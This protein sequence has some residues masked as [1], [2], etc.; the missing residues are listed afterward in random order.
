MSI[1]FLS[2]L[3][4]V[5][6]MSL[7]AQAETLPYPDSDSSDGYDSAYYAEAYSGSY[8]STPALESESSSKSIFPTQSYFE[9]L[10]P[11]D[12]R[13]GHGHVNIQNW[14]TDVNLCRMSSGSWNFSAI[15]GLRMTWFNGQGADEM[16]VDRLYTIWL[17][18]NASCVIS[19]KTRL[20]FGFTPEISTDFDTWTHNNIFFGGHAMITGPLNDRFSYG[21]GIGYYPQLGEAPMLPVLQFK[22]K[23]GNKWSLQ[24]EGARLS[25]TKMVGE[26]LTWGPFVSIVSGTWTIHHDRRVRQ[27]EWIS[28]VA[29]VG[30]N[31]GLGRWGSVRPRLMTDVG[32]SFGNSGTLKTSNGNHE[33]EKRHY[34][35]VFYL[36]ACIQFVF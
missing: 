21:I 11:M 14:V 31:I 2:S 7:A 10:G 29:G 3:S 22:W 13:N 12:S 4:L 25:Y 8:H 1:R 9:L 23:T 17:N 6:G 27:F 32:F 16:D 35:P 36:R 5:A 28:G 24:L 34:D 20:V 26:G 18:M 19:G 15:T 33:L 30:A